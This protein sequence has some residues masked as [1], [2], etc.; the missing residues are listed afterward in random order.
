MGIYKQGSR[1]WGRYK[2]QRIG[3][4]PPGSTMA[5]KDE[6]EAMRLYAAWVT[7]IKEGTTAKQDVTVAAYATRHL[8]Q[9]TQKRRVTR[10]LTATDSLPKGDKEALNKSA[11]ALKVC[12]ERLHLHEVMRVR[13]VTYDAATLLIS[14]LLNVVKTSLGP[15]KQNPRKQRH[16]KPSSARRMLM[17]FSRMMSSARREGYADS[18][19][20][21]GHEQMPQ[22]TRG[23]ALN[24][25]LYLTRD[26]VRRQLNNTRYSSKNPWAVEQS[27][28]VFY[29]GARLAEVSSLLV[30]D[31]HMGAGEKFI[32]IHHGDLKTASSQRQTPLWPRHEEVMRASFAQVPRN[33]D[34]LAF[35]AP[36][37][38]HLPLEQQKRM[39]RLRGTLRSAARRSVITKTVG[40]KIGR[41]SYISGRQEMVQV[42][43]LGRVSAVPTSYIAAE[44]GHATEA[45]IRTV[46]GH[47]PRSGVHQTILDWGEDD[48]VPY[49]AAYRKSRGRLARRLA[50]HVARQ[51]RQRRKKP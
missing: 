4:A 45:M 26:E 12:T 10:G 20:L 30:S 48:L 22:P 46:Y 18:N 23:S 47:L 27:V 51:A 24:K 21:L 7:S 1:W 13:Q 2:R 50:R 8:A 41:H 19:P 36:G 44:V 35:P 40:H 17:V 16:L 6:T 37:T 49:M 5:T 42:D 34:G 39:L 38:E 9:L 33:P 14:D 32:S 43:S 31:F 28:T 11:Y 29:T 15:D 25:A 3:L